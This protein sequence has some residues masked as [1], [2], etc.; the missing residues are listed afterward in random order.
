MESPISTKAL[1][2][3]DNAL[4]TTIF[5]S[6]SAVI[7]FATSCIRSGFPT[8]VPPNFITFIVQFSVFIY[9]NRPQSFILQGCKDSRSFYLLVAE[10]R[11]TP[12]ESFGPD[13][14]LL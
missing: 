12:K 9:R 13:A 7:N 3:P 6:L 10:I 11:D 5:G 2:V 8:E 14:E 4:S 1:V